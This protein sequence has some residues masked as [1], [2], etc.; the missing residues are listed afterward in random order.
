MYQ[1]DN[2]FAA[3]SGLGIANGILFGVYLF[4]KPQ[5]ANR[6][7]SIFLLLL[8]FRFAITTVSYFVRNPQHHFVDW[9]LLMNLTLGPAF[10]AYVLSLFK[11]DLSRA[12][13]PKHLWS[14]LFLGVALLLER[15]VLPLGS[16]FEPFQNAWFALNQVTMLHWIFYLVYTYRW[17]KGQLAEK[18]AQGLDISKVEQWLTGL[19]IFM[20]ILILGYSFN[21]ARVLCVIFCPLFYTIIV[22]FLLAFF[23]KNYSL[24]QKAFVFEPAKNNVLKSELVPQLQAQLQQ[25][26]QEE[27]SFQDATLTLDKLAQKMGCSSHVLSHYINNHEGCNFPDWLNR[28]RVN[29]A[30]QLLLDPQFEHLTI[31]A[32]AYD[33]GFNTLSVFNGAFKKLVGCTPSAFRKA[34][35]A[36][37]LPLSLK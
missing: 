15:N 5:T 29:H 36:I 19:F 9:G 20:G 21:N 2:L 25:F 31:A 6:Y 23:I 37:L 7:L 3:L 13:W 27:R 24:L 35:G 32:L 33:S 1:F 14:T 11:Q 28:Y 17:S 30:C 22:Y 4:K 16:S 18:K 8:S 12:F 34:G 10:L 26:M